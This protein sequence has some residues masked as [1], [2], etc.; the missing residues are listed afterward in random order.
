[1]KFQALAL[2]VQYETLQK[3][4]RPEM[5]CCTVVELVGELTMAQQVELSQVQKG[6]RISLF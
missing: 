4:A 3:K 6:I 2:G 1:M 5:V